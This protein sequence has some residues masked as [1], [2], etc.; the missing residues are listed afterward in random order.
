MRSELK[1]IREVYLTN[2]FSVTKLLRDM[3]KL[4]FPGL[5]ITVVVC[6][7]LAQRVA[8]LGGVA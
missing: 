2:S 1:D 6:L 4:R 3:L 8:L 5:K 7:C